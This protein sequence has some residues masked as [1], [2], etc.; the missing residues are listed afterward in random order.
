M[1]GDPDPD[2]PVSSTGRSRR[3]D[4]S[5]LR[6]RAE[7]VLKSPTTGEP[8]NLSEEETSRLL[9]ELQVHQVELEMQ[10]EELSRTRE[11]LEI[12]R[13]RYFHLY[14]MA[15]VGYCTVSR[16]GLILEANLTMARLL[17]VNRGA[18]INK[19]LSQFV[20][21]EDQNLYYL[22][23]GQ[24][25][26]NGQPQSF[27]VRMVDAAGQLPYVH[28]E[29]AR[30]E[31]EGRENVLRIVLVNITERIQLEEELRRARQA[32]DADSRAKSEFLANMSHEI[33]TPLNGIVGMA[34]VLEYSPLNPS[35]KECLEVIRSCSASL[36]SLINNVLDMAKV[37]SG[38]LELEIRDFSL[39]TGIREVVQ[40]LA[41]QVE[42]KGLRLTIDIPEEVPDS[43]SGDP[44]R[45]KQILINLLGNAVKFT[46]RGGIRIGVAICESGPGQVRLLL[47]VSD[48]GIGIR[49]E[50]IDKI[51]LPFTQADTSITRQYDGTGLG[52]AICLRLAQRMGG[53]IRARST[54]GSG[55]TFSLEVP[56]ALSK[57]TA[58]EPGRD[59]TGREAVSWRGPALRFLVVDDEESNRSVVAR[60]LSLAG[61]S[62][63]ECD[64][65]EDALRL[66][67]PGD[68]DLVLLDIQM[69]VRSGIEVLRTMREKEKENRRR[70]PVVAV[71]AHALQQ[72]REQM[73]GEDFDGF[74][75]KPVEIESLFAE[76]SR[77]LPKALREKGIPPERTP[78]P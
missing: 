62:V 16:Q 10:N 73:A 31:D 23:T 36:L 59:G 17:G 58:R 60:M 63:V 44:F 51:F 6:R 50:L 45:L 33:R 75:F 35:Q 56:F 72:E 22:Q 12:S 18:L 70:I 48:S 19:R 64:N 46:D 2:P 74:L 54:V 55:S 8:G 71:T 32:S 9:H 11:E 76:I 3:S 14:N 15:P 57:S 24:L 27:V 39:R 7:A 77:C 1:I 25:L 29:A 43:L 69:P 21:R 47:N 13:N 78:V 49:P 53:K 66:W 5:E 30:D 67:E 28:L 26:K 65:G 38:K 4:P 68:F 40:I 61:H 20:L 52:L 37:E 41:P 34:Q 42:K